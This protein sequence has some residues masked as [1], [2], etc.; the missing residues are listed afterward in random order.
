M[1]AQGVYPRI[2]TTGGV[3]ATTRPRW[4]ARAGGIV[5]AVGMFVSALAMWTLIPGIVLWIAPKFLAG[6]QLAYPLTL[7]GVCAAM[8]VLGVFLGRLNRLYCRLMAVAQGRGRPAAW[9]RPLCN[10]NEGRLQGG[11][12]DAIL[13]T[14]VTVA[15]IT[16][17]VWFI[18]FAECS[19]GGCY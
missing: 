1:G 19:G 8:V 6:H 18:F 16:M 13:V 7:L 14:S 4:L 9:R 3:A 15:A 5:V 11:V 2:A 12:L 10:D 17:S